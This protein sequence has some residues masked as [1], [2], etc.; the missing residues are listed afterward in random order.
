MAGER[1]E[2]EGVTATVMIVSIPRGHKQILN[3]VAEVLPGD[4]QP[5]LLQSGQARRVGDGLY[6]RPQAE[7]E[8]GGYSGGS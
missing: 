7:A 5:R 6:L 4:Q 1:V 8:P 3:E 2:T